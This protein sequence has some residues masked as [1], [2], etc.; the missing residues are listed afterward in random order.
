[1]LRSQLMK[2]GS[3]AG[4]SATRSSALTAAWESIGRLHP[5]FL[6]PGLSVELLAQHL[7]QWLTRIAAD[8]ICLQTLLGDDP[9]DRVFRQQL[10]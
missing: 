8:E 2:S 4:E 9:R 10:T 1:M 3:I 6:I 7:V 5:P